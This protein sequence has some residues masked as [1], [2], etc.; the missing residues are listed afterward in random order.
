MNIEQGISNYEMWR[1]EL[2]HSKFVIRNSIFLNSAVG[3]GTVPAG[4]GN[5]LMEGFMA[6]TE[7]RP[8]ENLKMRM[9]FGSIPYALCPTGIDDAFENNE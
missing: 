3:P 5:S 6:G 4:N 8:T 2:L 9:F 7:T 1:L